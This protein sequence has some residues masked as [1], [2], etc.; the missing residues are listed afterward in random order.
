MKAT[1]LPRVAKAVLPFEPATLPPFTVFDTTSG[2]PPPLKT[3]NI[4]AV[5]VVS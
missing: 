1:D 2:V 5:F 3:A 4:F